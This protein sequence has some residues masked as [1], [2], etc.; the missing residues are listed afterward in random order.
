M[1]TKWFKRGLMA[2]VIL[3][4]AGGFIFGTDMV[5]Y[6]RSSVRSVQTAVKDTVPI[7]FELRRGRDLLLEII[8]EMHANIRL[9]AQEEIEVANLKTDIE[10]SAKVLAEAGQQIKL[11]HKK[12]NLQHTNYVFGEHKYSRN[13]VKDELS[14]RFEQY[15]ES[16]I[17]LK[18]K[19]RLLAAREKSLNAAVQL[20]E[21]TRSQKRLLQDKIEGLAS[22][23]RLVR[24]AAVGSTIQVDS[25]KLAQT[26]KLIA[27]IKKR[28]DVAERVLAHE[29][30]FVQ[31]IPLDTVD[32]KD[33]LVQI[34]EYFTPTGNDS[35]LVA[36]EE[37]EQLCKANQ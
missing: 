17:I 10:T 35:D 7:E 6:I 12:M 5:S 25:S 36:G 21:K 32:E 3:C 37:V 16:E 30:R 22:Q 31:D 26:E 20:L 28:L 23:Y 14:R 24:A 11:L 8:P 19:H 18:S 2:V 1:V 29:S 34:D 9:I 15:K 33:L 27:E 13:A 4:L